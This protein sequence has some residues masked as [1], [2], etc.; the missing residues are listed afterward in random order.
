MGFTREQAS[1]ALNNTT[2]VEQATD[3]IL[4]NTIPTTSQNVSFDFLALLESQ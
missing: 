2:S 3:Y 4:T 1:V